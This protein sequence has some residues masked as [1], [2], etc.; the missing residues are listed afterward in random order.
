MTGKLDDTEIGSITPSSAKFTSVEINGLLLPVGIGQPGEIIAMNGGIADWKELPPL[1]IDVQ[2]FNAPGLDL[3]TKPSPAV[4]T[5]KLVFVQV[6]ASGAAGS[7]QC[8]GGGG[9]YNE[10]WIKADLLAPTEDVYVGQGGTLLN[11]DGE[12]SWFSSGYRQV[13][14]EGGSAN[15][16][17]GGIFGAGSTDG[18]APYG[19]SAGNGTSGGFSVH[20]GGG[21]GDDGK[22][23]G[24]SFWGGGGGGGNSLTGDGG[25]GGNSQMGGPGG[26]GAALPGYNGGYGG[27]SINDYIAGT[28]AGDNTGNINGTD[29]GAGGCGGGGT[30]TGIPGLGGNGRVRVT[31]FF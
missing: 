23:G 10:A 4:G 3:W 11:P 22:D 20:G 30:L 29:G 8:G 31:T 19:G 28:G 2:E 16:G 15:G 6:W 13:R 9:A 12:Y 5:P 27:T 18:G 17:G 21:A 24:R 1:S 26:G 14:A 25:A 7:T